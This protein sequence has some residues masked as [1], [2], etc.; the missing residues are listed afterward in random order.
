MTREELLEIGFEEIPHYTIGN[1]LTC[2]LTR[3][4]FISISCLGTP[5]EMIFLGEIDRKM[6]DK[7]NDLIVVRNYDYDGYTSLE[8]IQEFKNLLS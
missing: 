7:I 5:N 8:W 6:S 3:N 2:Q 4:R 1:G